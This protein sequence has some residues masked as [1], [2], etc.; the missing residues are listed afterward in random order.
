MDEILK[1]LKNATF[2][3]DN[4][5]APLFYVGAYADDIFIAY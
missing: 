2:P 5:Q 3:I 1:C 4:T